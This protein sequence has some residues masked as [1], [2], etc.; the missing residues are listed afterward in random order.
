MILSPCGFIDPFGGIIG[1][2]GCLLCAGRDGAQ[3]EMSKAFYSPCS[4]QAVLNQLDR[5]KRETVSLFYP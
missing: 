4:Q 2:S 1:C 5:C 3:P